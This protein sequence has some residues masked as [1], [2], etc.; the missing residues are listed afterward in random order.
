MSSRYIPHTEADIA[1]MLDA[2]NVDSIEALFEPIPEKL[3][4]ARPLHIPASASEQEVSRE[5]GRLA[6]KNA[7]TE[8]HDWFLGAGVYALTIPNFYFRQE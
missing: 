5:L 8:T 6:A 1:Q 4:L 3:R 2:I 7:N